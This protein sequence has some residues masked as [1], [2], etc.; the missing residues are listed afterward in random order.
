MNSVIDIGSNSVRLA[1]FADG[2]I[3]YR[4]KITAM[5]G[6]GLSNYGKILPHSAQNNENAIKS[7]I[8]VSKNYGVD[9]ESILAFATAAVRQSS[10]G[11]DFVEKI[12]NETGLNIEVL[13]EDAECRVA[14]IGALGNSDGA[15]LDVGGASSE[16]VI[17]RGGK[18]TYAKSL[19]EGAVK[20]TER[21]S[22]S[23]TALSSYLIKKVSEYGDLNL[24][25]LTA[26]GGTATSIGHVLSGDREYSAE[27]NHLRFVSITD[28]YAC[29]CKIKPYSI[30]ERSNIFHLEKSR[31]KTIYSGG[32]LIYTILKHFGLNGY[33]IS[34]SD[35]LQ[36]Y[37]MLKTGAK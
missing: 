32:I 24:T 1:I 17:Q 23:E 15:V 12:T 13:S 4:D 36:G 21:F 10:N 30:E 28:L 34:E 7:F 18:I 31:A 33:T 9:P 29:L 25:S 2:K 8:A 20:L 11:K 16:L 5:L 26:I 37:Y 27:R 22:E 6:E 35:N 19:D 3:I 14:V